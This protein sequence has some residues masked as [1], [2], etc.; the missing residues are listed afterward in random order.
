MA[1]S[2]CRHCTTYGVV[3]HWFYIICCPISALVLD[4]IK[5]NIGT[6]IFFFYR[7]NQNCF[8]GAY[9]VIAYKQKLTISDE[10]IGYKKGLY[11]EKLRDVYI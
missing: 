7:T 9:F 10:N 3:P 2:Q 11:F 6:C 5:S 8:Y 1:K 4:H